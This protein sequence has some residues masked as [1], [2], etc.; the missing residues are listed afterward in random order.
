MYPAR[1]RVNF[2]SV[3]MDRLVLELFMMAL[4]S[5]DLIL[6]WPYI[7]LHL[8]TNHVNTCFVDIK[9]YLLLI[10][11]IYYNS[12]FVYHACMAKTTIYQKLTRY[13]FYTCYTSVL[14]PCTAG[15]VVLSRWQHLPNYATTKHQMIPPAV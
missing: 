7:L 10:G 5:V 4:G 14:K 15:T 11:S 3:W 1:K 2:P 13:M 9:R 12:G 6:T 8:N